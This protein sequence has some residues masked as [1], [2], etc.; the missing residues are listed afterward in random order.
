MGLINI[1]VCEIELKDI[2]CDNTDKI[3]ILL[4]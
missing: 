1:F 2:F 3:P 4:R